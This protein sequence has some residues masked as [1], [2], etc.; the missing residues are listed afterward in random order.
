MPRPEKRRDRS[1]LRG[2]VRF[3]L[4]ALAILISLPPSNLSAQY[5]GRTYAITGARLVTVAG[6][7]I[8]NG[9]IVL[10]GGL[11]EALGAEVTPP[12]DAVLIDGDSLTVYPGF[13]DAYSQAGLVLPGGD[14]REYA[15]NIAHRLATEHFD[16]DSSDLP[17]Y[18]EQGLTSA[19]IARSD[20]VFGGQA[21]LMNLMGTDVPSMTVKAPVVQVMGYQGQ[22]D[23][24]GTLMA[25]VAYQRQTLIDAAYHDMLQTRYQQAPRSMVRPPADPDLE[26]LIPVAKGE[27]PVMAI[28]EIENDFK[29]LRKLVEEYGIQYWIAGAVEA[30]R[31]PDLIREAG[32]PVLVTLDFPSIAEV[33]G[34]QFDR[35]YKNLTEDEKKELDDRDKAAVHSNPA[36]VFQAGVPFA[37]ATGGMSSPTSF[38]KNLRLAVEAGL[39]AEEALKALTINPATIFGV[40]DVMGTLEPGKI[41]NLTVTHG[42]I[43]T[44]EDAY[45]AHVFVDGRKES[46][47]KPKPPSAGGSGAAAGSWT[48]TVSLGGESANGTLDLTQDGETVTGELSI[49]GMSMNFEGTISEGTLEMTG[50]VPEVGSVTLTATIQGDEM[51]GSIGLGPMG[52]ADF[53]GNR[54]PGGSA[55]ERRVGR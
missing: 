2:A 54:N 21:V 34:Y 14:D 9:T 19:L 55:A 7:I 37:L 32:V 53:S 49:E 45:V 38:L 35:A 36:A 28:V 22:Q 8:E 40:A 26:A 24:P 51:S 41:A 1:L 52:T 17:A 4:P 30:F 15:G 3:L 39:P 44:D 27:A 18:R 11:I 47:D 20:G 43:F 12:A 25:V 33:T 48:V 16:P 23:Y 6:D 50:A 46:F 13:I 29:R 5:E 42:D 10:R 31:V